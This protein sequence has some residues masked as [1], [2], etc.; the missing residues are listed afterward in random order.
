M[1][2]PREAGMVVVLLL[3]LSG[4]AGVPQRSYWTAPPEPL[5][6]GAEAW[7]SS[8]LWSWWRRPRT[9]SDSEVPQA[10]APV[11]AATSGSGGT[12]GESPS[13][14]E[15][16]PE[17]RDGLLRRIPLLG[18]LWNDGER[19]RTQPSAVADLWRVPGPWGGEVTAAAGPT[20]TA[21]PTQ[22]ADSTGGAS[23]AARSQATSRRRRPTAPAAA[24]APASAPASAPSGGG[25]DSGTEA[26]GVVTLDVSGPGAGSG[27]ADL[28]PPRGPEDLRAALGAPPSPA[29]TERAAP[30]NGADRLGP[31]RPVD[32]AAIPASARAAEAAPPPVAP[33]S[34]PRD[35]LPG[36]ATATPDAEAT[37]PPPPPPPTLRANPAPPSVTPVGEPVTTPP[38]PSAA[39]AGE[40]SATGAE[41]APSGAASAA[42]AQTTSPGSGPQLIATSAQGTSSTALPPPVAILPQSRCCL[43]G[44]LCPLKNHG[45]FP[46]SQLP[47]ATFPASYQSFLPCASS[48]SP[49]IQGCSSPCESMPVV[50]VKKPCFLRT[51]LHKVTCPGEGC[52]CG[53]G[54]CG[55]HGAVVTPT[56]QLGVLSPQASLAPPVYDAATRAWLARWAATEPRSANQ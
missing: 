24:A 11:M 17:R 40:G 51:W 27:P 16:W 31:G 6:N 8:R 20:A 21:G 2:R 45:P 32:P 46:S 33:D 50:K 9:G 22:T 38:A 54:D 35:P 7:P 43:L 41:P 28:S 56:S 55:R 18:R 29:A 52:G 47:A 48:A 5:A 37:Q 34:A 39:A 4:C 12:D 30:S 25:R 44:R 10:A 13:S 26:A 36:T 14:S 1:R 19:D 3:G 23:L 53:S 49:C 42:P 15:I